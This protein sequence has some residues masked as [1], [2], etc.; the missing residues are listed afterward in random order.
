[1][2]MAFSLRIEM[3]PFVDL[4]VYP[5]YGKLSARLVWRTHDGYE[6][7]HFEVWK[8]PD[9]LNNWQL[10]GTVQ[11]REREF[12]D[13]NLIFRGK[14]DEAY[15]KVTMLYNDRVFVSDV[16]ST[17]GKITRKE[18]GVARHI[19]EHEWQTMRRFTPIKIFKMRS[20]GP[21]CSNCVDS[22]TGQRIGISLCATC[23]GTAFEGGYYPAI[24]SYM[25]VGSIGTKI[26][27]DSREGA[28]SKDPVKI[29][30]RMMAYP[31]LEKN[32]MIIN[33]GADRRYLVDTIDYGFFNGKI[34]VYSEVTLQLMPRN[35]IRYKF[36]L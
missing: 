16:V 27:D 33:P 23:F 22:E 4:S 24:D 25:Q 14:W 36:P 21:D 30:S 7:S 19:M 17:F 31:N 6:R 15:Y 2:F 13:V 9:G 5:T 1:M 26:Q 32:D 20:D 3:N 18:F 10:I 35:D 29:R 34:P 28:G 12:T 11:G 8:S